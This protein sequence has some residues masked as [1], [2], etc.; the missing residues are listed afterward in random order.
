MGL[1]AS[2]GEVASPAVV[3]TIHR[4]ALAQQG[5]ADDGEAARGCPVQAAP[6]TS[7][8]QA[9]CRSCIQQHYYGFSMASLTGPEERGVSVLVHGIHVC[10][11]LQQQLAA[12]AV[13]CKRGSVQSWGEKQS[14]L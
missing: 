14:M 3:S 4:Q 5:G 11:V 1:S 6:P 9:N 12:A 10:T 8:Q 7:I 13:A 2:Q